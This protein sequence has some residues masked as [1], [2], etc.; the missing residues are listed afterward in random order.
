MA[1]ARA[2]SKTTLTFGLVSCPVSLYRAVGEAE[3]PRASAWDR[4]DGAPPGGIRWKRGRWCRE[5]SGPHG[6][7]RVP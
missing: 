6:S 5:P 7:S 3:K 2:S 1:D 4:P